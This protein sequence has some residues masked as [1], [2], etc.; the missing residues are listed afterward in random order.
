M[1]FRFRMAFG[2]LALVVGLAILVPLSGGITSPVGA[3]EKQLRT[4]SVKL[5]PGATAR[6]AGGRANVRGFGVSGTFS[7][8]CQGTGTCSIAT[9]PGKLICLKG[10]GGTA[11]KDLC[12]MMVVT[13]DSSALIQ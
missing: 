9:V 3:A 7:C 4:T 11:C 2:R 5:K 13:G 1:C 12:E 10:I 8:E 6:I